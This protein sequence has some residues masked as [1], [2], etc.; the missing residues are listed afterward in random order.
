MRHRANVPDRWLT[1]RAIHA[2]LIHA[3]IFVHQ[4]LLARLAATVDADRSAWAILIELTIRG[5][6]APTEV[7]DTT[8]VTVQVAVARVGGQEVAAA[9]NAGLAVWTFRVCLTT[10]WVEADAVNALQAEQAV[11]RCVTTE[12][13]QAP[14]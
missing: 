9:V 14:V 13:W 7:A 6:F 4:A 8:G 1:A 2:D 12:H 11:V 10:T 3:A 5:L